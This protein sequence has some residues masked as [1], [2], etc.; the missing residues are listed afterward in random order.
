MKFAKNVIILIDFMDEFCRSMKPLQTLKT[1]EWDIRLHT[2][3]ARSVALFEGS[4]FVTREYTECTEGVVWREPR[5]TRNA[6]K[7]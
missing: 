3:R 1:Q 6:R 7:V 4:I 2:P 5:N